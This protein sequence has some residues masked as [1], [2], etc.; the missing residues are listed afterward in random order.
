MPPKT[1]LKVKLTPP[2]SDEEENET[3]P[4]EPGSNPPSDSH[5]S[6]SLVAA[7]KM[8]HQLEKQIQA[9]KKAGEE[10][11]KLRKAVKND[12]VTMQVLRNENHRLAE[13]EFGMTGI[14]AKYKIE[15]H[16]LIR[17]NDGLKRDKGALEGEVRRLR[18]LLE[19]A[20]VMDYET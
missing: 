14:A 18:S 20:G 3:E 1:A 17:E 4:A 5:I 13:R 11:E 6:R 16:N 2:N 15:Q 8:K 12:A 7:R 9:L 19:R 10:D